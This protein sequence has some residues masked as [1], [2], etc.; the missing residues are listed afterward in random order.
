MS[1]EAGL[2]L[3]RLWDH[4]NWNKHYASWLFNS[5]MMLQNW[6]KQVTNLVIMLYYILVD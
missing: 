5:S 4:I 1:S 6:K 2:K 3:S